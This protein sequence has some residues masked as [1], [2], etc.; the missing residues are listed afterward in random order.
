[1]HCSEKTYEAVPFEICQQLKSNWLSTIQESADAEMTND[2]R[3]NGSSSTAQ[4]G[5][6]NAQSQVKKLV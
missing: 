5:Y 2:E 3:P 6:K 4:L 1:M